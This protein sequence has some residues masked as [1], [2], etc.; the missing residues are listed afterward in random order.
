MIRVSNSQKLL[1]GVFLVLVSIISSVV[2]ATVTINT[3]NRFEFGQGLYQVGACDSF[4]D[5]TAETDGTNITEVIID[6]LDISSCP[7]TYLR[8]KFFGSGTAPLNLYQESTTAV[9]RILLYIN[10]Q[11]GR[12]RGIDFLNSR[13][14][15]PNPYEDSCSDFL[16]QDCKS[17]G[18]LDLDYLEGR[19]RLIFAQPMAVPGAFNSFTIET[20]SEPFPTSTDC[21]IDPLVTGVAQNPG[22]LL[23]GA[24]IDNLTI[25]NCA[26]KYIRIRFFEDPDPNPLGIYED[27]VTEVNRILLYVNGQSDFLTGLE[28]IHSQGLRVQ[29][30]QQCTSGLNPDCRTDGILSLDY[31]NGRYTLTFETPTATFNDVDRYQVDVADE[32]P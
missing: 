12:I 5:I 31:L 22:S 18:Y 17:D 20:A 14:L 24:I 1:L 29:S 9:N 30:Y 4:V 2:A 15:V 21:N 25:Q 16:L 6:G 8:I 7:D 13:G 27:S 19:Y 10:G 26:E 28:F 23:A 32:L 3:D 11:S